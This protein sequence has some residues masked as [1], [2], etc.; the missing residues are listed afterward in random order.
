MKNKVTH[1]IYAEKV[2]QGVCVKNV[3]FGFAH[4][5]VALKQPW[6]SKYLLRQRK[7]QSHQED[8]PVNGMEPDNILSDQM[9]VCRPQLVELFAAFSVAVIANTGNIVGQRIQPY[10]GYVLWIKADRNAP[11]KGSSGNA[12]ILKSWKKEVIHHLIFA[13]YR[14]DKVWMLINIVN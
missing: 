14:L 7:I 1:C 13:G 12:Q 4:L 10:I 9:Q 3:S 6:M 11:G 8:W 2:Y 5:A